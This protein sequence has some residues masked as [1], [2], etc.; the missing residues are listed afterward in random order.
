MSPKGPSFIFFYFA[1]ECMFK[2]SQRPPFLYFSVPCDL[3]ETKKNWKKFVEK[4]QKK[5]DFFPHAGT[6]EENTRHIE[7]LLLFLSLRYGADLGRFRLVYVWKSRGETKGFPFGNVSALCNL[8]C[9][10]FF[11]RSNFILTLF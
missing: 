1:K 7:V 10:N 8:H 3:P 9:K 11:N 5:S 4:F 6:V 2:I